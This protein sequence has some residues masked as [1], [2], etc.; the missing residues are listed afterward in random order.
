MSCWA[1]P[2]EAHPGRRMEGNRLPSSTSC[3]LDHICNSVHFWGPVQKTWIKRSLGKL[4]KLSSYLTG[5]SPDQLDPNPE[6]P[7]LWAEGQTKVLLR[8][9][10]TW[11]NL[12]LV[13][14]TL[15]FPSGFHFATDHKKFG[16]HKQS[17]KHI[18]DGKK[19]SPD[20]FWPRKYSCHMLKKPS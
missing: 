11:I 1:V 12:Y 5:Y 6:L 19:Q 18:V 3:S 17:I 15:E 14:E 4:S 16:T 10:S 13:K 20:G 2:T 8:S 7:L 9:L